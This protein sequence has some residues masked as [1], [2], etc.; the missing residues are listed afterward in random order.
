MLDWDGM[1][2]AVESTER[3]PEG[4]AAE[5]ISLFGSG[6][7]G[8]LEKAYEAISQDSSCHAGWAALAMVDM[9]PDSVYMD[10][11]FSRALSLA[12]EDDP[13]LTEAMA[14][15][16]LSTGNPG[17]AAEYASSALACDSS[18]AP[19]WLTLSMALTDL[20][21]YQEALQISGESIEAQPG[22]IQLLHQYASALD[23]AGYTPEAINAYEEVIR[24]DPERAAAYADL[25]LLYESTKRD[26]D[27]V[28]AY[29]RLLEIAPDY[30]WAWGELAALQEDAGRPDLADSFFNRSVELNPDDSWALYRLGRLR[31]S[32][33]PGSAMEF[34]LSSVR[35]APE[36]CDAWQELVFL[37]ES[38]GDMSSAEMALRKCTELDPQA[39]LFGEL[40]WV[41]ENEGM[42]AEAAEAYESGISMDS[43]YL[44]GWQRRGDLYLQDEDLSSAEAWFREAL[45]S[46]E[47]PDPLILK[48]LGAVFV[49]RGTLD[50]AATF[51]RRSLELDPSDRAAWL[52]LA[53]SCISLGDTGYAM[54]CLD[55][56]LALGGDT[57]SVL[58]S[59]SFLL[60]IAGRWEES[61]AVT[62]GM[63]AERPD[64]WITA[65]WS[66]LDDGFTDMA[67]YC[68]LKALESAPPDP[69]GLISLGELFGDLRRPDLQRDCYAM[70]ARSPFRRAEHTVSIANYY[71]Q[72]EMYDRSIELLTEE[73]STGGWDPEVTTAL[74]EAYLFDDQLDRAEELLDEIILH[75]PFSV[76]A[77]CYLGLIEENRGNP[78]AAA[79]RYLEALRIESGY[80]Y[81]EDRLRFISGEDYDPSYHRNKSRV[82]AW[83]LWIDLSSTG[84]NLDEQNYGGGGSVKLN[85][86]RS[87]S[88]I[89][90]ETRGSAEI[91]DDRDFRRSA[92]ASLSA[93]HFL[94]R[95][96]YAGASTSWDRQPLTVR[97]WQVS[98]YLAAGWKSWP[99]SWIWVAPEIGAGLVNTRWDTSLERTTE[100]TTYSSLSIWAKTRADWLPS[101]WLSGALYLPP[102]DPGGLVANGVGELEFNLPGPLSLVLGTS[103]D[104]TRTPVVESWKKLDS[105][106]YLRLRL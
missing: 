71:F 70:A 78:E 22:S 66:C 104:Y 73:Y 77:I 74:A 51:F 56:C 11:I 10:S 86:G 9:R 63:L 32:T 53:R 101:L 103:L 13:V 102:E 75:D 37:Y 49:A 14:Y 15:W 83:N 40:G 82:L 67:M 61:A 20:N 68:A 48:Q 7:P 59:N 21:L 16:L 88:S 65:G 69:W 98:S 89:S 34:L 93:E 27:A 42:P 28:K 81:A 96:L 35:L 105:E 2:E 1:L 97:P 31:S 99:F 46:L 54:V 84:G 43:Q 80:T 76:Y 90:L 62:D 58:A 6:Y 52:S 100:W 64:G 79:D 95:H 39:W 26:G 106:V 72:T 60:E 94:S 8:A 17:K 57:V 30:G 4:L 38:A 91:R 36:F 24:I 55:S 3:S 23:A 19:A 25:G 44:Y 47:T 18:F 87:G 92:W 85:Y 45:D 29:R 50:S 5:A 41:L 33:D 12:E